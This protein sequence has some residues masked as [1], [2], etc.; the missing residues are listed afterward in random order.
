MRV[1]FVQAVDGA[2]LTSVTANKG[3]NYGL[4]GAP[5]DAV[6][7]VSGG[8]LGD[9]G[10]YVEG[11]VMVELKGALV[12]PGS[13]EYS[14]D[15]AA[16]LPYLPGEMISG[17][18][19]GETIVTFYA[20][21]DPDA[22]PIEVTVEIDET[23]PTVDLDQPIAIVGP[24]DSVDPASIAVCADPVPGSGL[25]DLDPDTAPD[26]LLSSDSYTLEVPGRDPIGPFTLTSAL[27]RD[28]AGNETSESQ[29]A[30]ILDGVEGDN[31]YFTT[32]VILGIL[33]GAADTA[34]V[35]LNG[36][37][38]EPYEEPVTVDVSTTVVVIVGDDQ[39]QF[40]VLVDL[41]RPHG[42]RLAGARR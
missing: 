2:G 17:A 40:E 29:S 30:L 33:G 35:G 24:G 16:R 6:P 18:D 27:G 3:A 14:I 31:G 5:A 13:H 25:R 34:L 26:C 42:D 37:T 28:V 8:V 10:W 41:R 38:P 9:D 23:A 19:D 32:P 11:P 1:F 36:A 22:L 21:T 7:F 4:V 12:E 39:I 20:L 15:G